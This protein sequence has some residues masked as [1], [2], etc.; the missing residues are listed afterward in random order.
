MNACK[1]FCCGQINETE[2]CKSG[3]MM[4]QV[5]RFETLI[6][7]KKTMLKLGTKYQSKLTGRGKKS[8]R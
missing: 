7:N 4:V 2:K 8:V 1:S 5:V 6:T 3:N